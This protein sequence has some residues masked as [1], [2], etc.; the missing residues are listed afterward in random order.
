MKILTDEEIKEV[1]EHIWDEA[2]EFDHQPTDWELELHVYRKVLEAQLE[3]WEES[4]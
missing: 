1:V 2:V 4:C 3:K